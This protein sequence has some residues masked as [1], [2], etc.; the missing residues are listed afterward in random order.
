MNNTQQN[1]CMYKRL[2]RTF[3]NAIDMILSI[4]HKKHSV[5]AGSST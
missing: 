2:K 1:V 3:F 5:S 4:K